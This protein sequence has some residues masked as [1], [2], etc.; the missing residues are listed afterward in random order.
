MLFLYL[1][2]ELRN[3][4]VN[5]EQLKQHSDFLFVDECV[6]AFQCFEKVPW[7]FGNLGSSNFQPTGVALL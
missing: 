3:S 6:Y 7:A 5:L 1:C 4:L 2:Y